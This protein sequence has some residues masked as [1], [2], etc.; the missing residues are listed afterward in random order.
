MTSI[1]MITGLFAGIAVC[2]ATLY[3]VAQAML[4]EGTLRWA[5]LALVVLTLIV[6][7]ALLE[8]EIPLA[9]LG[10][11][12]LLLV[13]VWV[14]TIERGWYRLFPGVVQLF[15]VVLILGYVALNP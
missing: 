7:G 9:R 1:L 3:S 5:H 15:A 4:R 10:A 14:F 8:R 6:M 2:M 13:A 11:V 12:P